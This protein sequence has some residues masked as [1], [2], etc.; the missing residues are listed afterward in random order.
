MA[1]EIDVNF[2]VW[3]QIFHIFI[4]ETENS[5]PQLVLNVPPSQSL[6][7]AK[8]KAQKIR[9]QNPQAFRVFIK[10]RSC[11]KEGKIIT[12]IFEM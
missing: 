3:E 6:I 8:Q 4:Q 2:E 1:K 12:K 9:Q 5:K 10:G 11:G 7:T